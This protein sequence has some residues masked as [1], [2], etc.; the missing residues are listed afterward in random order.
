M[1]KCFINIFLDS[2][3]SSN[4]V[5]A[6]DRTKTCSIKTIYHTDQCHLDFNR[7]SYT[8][9]PLK[10]GNFEQAQTIYLRT[11]FHQI[12]LKGLWNLLLAPKSIIDEYENKHKVPQNLLP[13]CQQKQESVWKPGSTGNRKQYMNKLNHYLIFKFVL[14]NTE[15]GLTLLIF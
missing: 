1:N 13:S 12:G 2:K 15:K 7:T 10:T 5:K 6:F 8:H 14:N 9:K 11:L 3:V 4:I